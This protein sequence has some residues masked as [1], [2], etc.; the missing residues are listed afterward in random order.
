MIC[1]YTY[2]CFAQFFLAAFSQ[3]SVYQYVML[4]LARRNIAHNSSSVIPPRRRTHTANG[5]YWLLGPQGKT[6]LS[7]HYGRNVCIPGLHFLAGA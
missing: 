6:D 5:P 4:L 2:Y 7:L 1:P 3:A